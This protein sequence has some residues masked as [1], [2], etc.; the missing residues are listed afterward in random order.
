MVVDGTGQPPFQGDL[1]TKGDRI[2]AVAPS[3]GGMAEKV[4]EAEGLAVAPGFIDIHSHIDRFIF[5]HPLAES[6]IFQG[7][8]SD[9]AGNCGIGTFP[10]NPCWKAVLTDDL[11]MHSFHLPPEG[12]T[13]TDFTQYADRIDRLGLGLNL[14]PLVPHG[15]L[16]IAVMGAENRAPEPNELA[17]MKELLHISLKQGA[18]GMST[19]LVYPPG[20]FSKTDELVALAKILARYQALYASHI[21]GEGATLFQALDEA[22][23]IGRESGVRVEVA[24]LKAMGRENWGRGREV[25]AKLEEARKKG[26]DI[27]ADQYPYEAASTSL[28]ALIPQWAHDGGVEEMLKRLVTSGLKEKIRGEILQSIQFRGGPER[29]LIAGVMSH[30]NAG[31]AGKNIAQIAQLW[32]TTPVEIVVRL[33]LE[34]RAGVSAI[35]F[36]MSEEDVVTIVANEKVAVGTDGAGFHAIEDVAQSPHPRSY[37]TF[38]RVLGLYTREKGLLSLPVAVHKMTGLPASRL[39]LSDRGLLRAGWV[40]DLVLFDPIQIQDR[41]QFN[42]PHQYP[43]G[44]PHVIVNGQ[45]VVWDGKLTGNAPGRVLRKLII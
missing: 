5:K 8:T 33:L 1:A 2:A 32:K 40:A 37:G 31:L 9:V 7:V 29:I 16:R 39:G 10:I 12:L 36:T 11:K 41:S 6:K 3:L 14:I 4:I 25:L 20:I 38:P 30:E 13:W 27:T 42:N 21:R 43:A 23:Q 35:Y 15:A 26:V 45:P 18:W 22:I 34:E 44:I 24:H 28:A 17:R 19:G